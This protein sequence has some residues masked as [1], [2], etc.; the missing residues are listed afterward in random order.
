MALAVR[1]NCPGRSSKEV[2][3][4]ETV[5]KTSSEAGRSSKKMAGGAVKRLDQEEQ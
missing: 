4:G 2:G 5:K 1:R 3:L